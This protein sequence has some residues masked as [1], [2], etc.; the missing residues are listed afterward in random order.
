MTLSYHPDADAEFLVLRQMG[1]VA[2]LKGLALAVMRNNLIDAG[3]QPLVRPGEFIG[4]GRVHSALFL[5]PFT[6]SLINEV[7]FVFEEFGLDVRVLAI[8]ATLLGLAVGLRR[9]GNAIQRARRLSR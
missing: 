7:R 2:L 8:D 6:V 9:G 1:S 4:P 5:V 3:I